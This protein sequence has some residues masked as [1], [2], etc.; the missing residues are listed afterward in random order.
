[1]CEATRIHDHLRRNDAIVLR[2]ELFV[3]AWEHCSVR[4]A[5]SSWR[6]GEHN[7]PGE[8]SL[9]TIL[10]FKAFASRRGERSRGWWR[11]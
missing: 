8:P 2:L 4:Q 10:T 3:A 9:R 11:E 5:R 7:P 6:G 1:V